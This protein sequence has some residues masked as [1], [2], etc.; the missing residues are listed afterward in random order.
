MS[1]PYFRLSDA[2]LLIWSNDFLEHIAA[3]P[4]AYGLTAVQ[5]TDYGTTRQAF[6]AALET[7]R[8]NS[9][10]TPV[11]SQVKKATRE[12]LLATTRY[13]VSTIN[14][15]PATTDAQRDELGI[16]IRK[17]PSRVPVPESVPILELVSLVGRV[18]KIGLRSSES[19]RGRPA[20]VQGASLYSY[21]GDTAPIHA[22]AWK[23]EGLVTK[24]KFDI[25]FGQS[26]QASTA[27]LAVSWYNERGEAGMSSDPL[28]I[29]LPATSMVPNN[30]VIKIAA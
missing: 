22:E 5:A 24:V 18:A 8:N 27:W 12:S 10:R 17:K 7:W 6:V 4:T 9:T 29:H 16:K 2:D 15:N 20:G 28:A 3:T 14:T 19:S 26:S 13:L 30:A 25:D 11:A 1:L 23:F 21:I